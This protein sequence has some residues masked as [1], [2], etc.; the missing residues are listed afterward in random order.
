MV[1]MVQLKKNEVNTDLGQENN[2]LENLYPVSK[3]ELKEVCKVLGD[4]FSKDPLMEA[5]DLKGE[6]ISK[7]YEMFIR[8]CLRYGRVYATSEELE[9]IMA[10][11]PS[12]YGNMRAWQIIRSGAIFPA[13]KIYK[14]F[15]KKILETL[16]V[17]E[18][19][20]TNFMI[21]PHLY[22]SVLGVSQKNQ[23]KGFGG[24]MLRAL[25]EKAENEGLPIYF[26]TE[27][28]GN[29]QFY[30][31]CGFEVIKKITL[32]HFNL[33]MWYLVSKKYRSL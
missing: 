10:M 8:Y 7:M 23:R 18:E 30:K 13:L 27:T 17:M 19:E 29:V 16:K 6:E 33:P 3:K 1:E 25:I 28:E 11:L 22:L 14:K 5:W 15:D 32:P 9:G 24:K 2:L 31:K 20:K 26:E 12:K 4:A 21:H